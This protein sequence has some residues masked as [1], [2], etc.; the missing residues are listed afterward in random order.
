MFP[1]QAKC[2]KCNHVCAADSTRDFNK[3][4]ADAECEK[5][6]KLVVEQDGGFVK[7]ERTR[8]K[9]GTFKVTCAPCMKRN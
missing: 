4:Y 2:K 7:A 8:T 5:G 1:V 6:G 3:E 9:D